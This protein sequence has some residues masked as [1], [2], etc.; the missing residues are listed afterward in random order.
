[1]SPF[2]VY[3][4][5]GQSN[6]LGTSDDP[7]R[8]GELPPA[9]DASDRSV[10]FWWSNVESA[11]VAYGDSCSKITALQIQQGNADNPCFWGPEFGFARRMRERS[12]AQPILLVK[13]SRGGGGNQFWLKGSGHMYRHIVTQVRAAVATLAPEQGYRVRALLYVQGESDSDDESS[14]SGERLAALIRNLREDLPCA[15]SLVG[16]V[17]GIACVAEARKLR[18]DRVRRQQR[19]LAASNPGLCCYVPI[20]ATFVFSL[21]LARALSPCAY[22]L[23]KIMSAGAG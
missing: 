20:P 9:A 17:G 22:V 8:C 1:M 4:L 11:D 2:D 23:H 3:V 6:S 13:V 7:A 15:Q 5:T 18:C 10:H 12:P 21:S 14:R 19:A 16:V